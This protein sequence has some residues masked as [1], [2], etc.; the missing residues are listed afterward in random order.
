MWLWLRRYR[1]KT[2]L[3]SCMMGGVSLMRIE[4]LTLYGRQ[5]TKLKI[6]VGDC[7]IFLEAETPEELETWVEHFQVLLPKRQGALKKRKERKGEQS[8]G[9]GGTGAVDRCNSQKIDSC[10]RTAH[11]TAGLT[12][13]CLSRP[14]ACF[15]TGTSDILC[16]RTSSCVIMIVMAATRGGPPSRGW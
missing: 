12:C 9:G 2:D 8:P 5:G 16:C 11:G 4:Q 13:W 3:R 1:Y 14:L 7:M 15:R 6:N 10:R